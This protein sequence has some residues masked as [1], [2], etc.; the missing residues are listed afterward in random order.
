[1][2]KTPIHPSTAGFLQPVIDAEL[3]LAEAPE[4]H[5]RVMEGRSHGK[6]TLIA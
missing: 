6:I 4:A 3:P 1:M 5:H 2:S